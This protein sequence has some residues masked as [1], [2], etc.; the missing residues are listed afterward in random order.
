VNGQSPVFVNNR[1]HA[2]STGDFSLD[3]VR[4]LM[5]LAAADGEN[6]RAEARGLAATH[7]IEVRSKIADLQGMERILASAIRDCDARQ[8]PR[9]PLIEVL[10]GE[11]RQRLSMTQP[12]SQFSNWRIVL[13]ECSGGCG[14]LGTFIPH[15]IGAMTIAGLAPAG[16]LVG[17]GVSLIGSGLFYGLPIPVQPI[18]AVSAVILTSGLQAGEIAAAGMMLG[19][20][21]L[22]LGVSLTISWFARLIPQ[23]VSTGLQLGLGLLMGVLGI[24]LVLRTPWLGIGAAAL[25]V[26]LMRMPYCPAATLMLV[27]ATV[28]GWSVHEVN[29]PR[30]RDDCL[31]FAAARHAGGLAGCVAG[32]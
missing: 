16:V 22:A 25:L 31:E 12:R 2:G 32:V 5:R 24:E 11:S 28:A 20:I 30:Q 4:A 26:V 3:E 17:F 10:S 23:S 8:Q 18:K 19:A 21:L 13:W 6:V 14:D 27:A 9:C 15:V 7:L 29:F 1:R